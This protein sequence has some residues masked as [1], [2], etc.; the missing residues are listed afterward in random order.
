MSG[1]PP[2]PRPPRNRIP[3]AGLPGRKDLTD[4]TAAGSGEDYLF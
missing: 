2:N 3:Q 1:V 4:G